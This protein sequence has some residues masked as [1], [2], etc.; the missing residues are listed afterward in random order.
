MTVFEQLDRTLLPGFER[1][2]VPTPQGPVLALVGGGGPPLLMLHG[3]PQTHL[4]WH[5]IAPRLAERFTVVLTDLRGRGESHKP[6]HTPD[7]HPYSKREMAAEQVAVMAHLGFTRFRLVGH[8]RGARVARRLALDHPDAVESLAVM[9]IVPALDFYER[10]NATIA[11]DYFYFFFLTQPHPLP[12]RL[13][14][15]D[16]R[17]F[18]GNILTSL[19]TAHVPYHDG[20]LGAYLQTSTTPEAIA[21]MCECFRAGITHDIE[22][23]RVDRAAGRGIACPTMVFWGENG[24]VGRHFDIPGIWRGW[25][26]DLELAPLPS[27]HFIP[28][29]APE[30]V[31]DTLSGFLQ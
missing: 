12:E 25:A 23:D 24:V 2:M 17:G 27:G 5:Q 10:A 22:A 26:P 21:A 7:H 20:A 18:M 16:P 3:D 15:G 19:S 8:D 14:A 9:D 6:G 1:K 30:L 11:Q 31:L 4:C 13:I 28:E 29:E